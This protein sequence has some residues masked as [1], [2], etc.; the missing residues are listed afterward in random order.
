MAQLSAGVSST[1]AA[2]AVR[3]ATRNIRFTVLLCVV[4][5]CGCFAAAA[6]LQMRNDRMHALAQARYFEA[7]RALDVAATAASGLDRLAASGR[8]FAGGKTI[9]GASAGVRNITVFDSTGL[10]LTTLGGGDSQSL[11]LDAITSGKPGV[12]A[13]GTLTLPFGDKIVAVAFDPRALVPARLLSRAAL[14]LNSGEVLLRDAAWSGSGSAF[15]V[16]GWPVAVRTSVDEDAALAA[17]TGALPLYLFVILGPS[18]VGAALAAVFVREFERR[19]RASQAIRSLRATRPVEARLLVRLAGA[20]RRAVEDGRA[21]SEFIAHMSHELR[22]PLN[23]IIG[24]S[25]VIERGFYGTVGHAKYVEYA[26][27]INEAGR[28]L[29]N[30]IGDI[31]EFANVEAGRY[32]L[33]P[34]TI[35]VAAVAAACVAEHAGRAFSRR[36][37]LELGFADARPTL[38]DPLAVNRI[39]TSLIGNALAYTQEGGLVRVEVR[40]EEAAIVVRVTDNGHGFTRAEVAKAGT[41]FRRF[42][43]PGATTGAGMG[44]AIAM[45]LA[46]RMGGAIRL[47]GTPGGG[48]IAELRLPKM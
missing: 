28:A 23:A 38:A 44:L 12:Y 6:G 36:I 2:G 45:S 11:P 24:F 7:Q 4:L 41:P 18:L 16:A 9:D 35:D 40:E 25:E 26:H 27:D 20:E 31:L 33:Q 8:A 22:T 5:I 47:D 21:K 34:A 19:A 48:S 37:A 15:A 39:L 30:K 29:H 1:L 46:R 3:L 32:P 14:V 43:R 10:A 42:D 17:W 13:P